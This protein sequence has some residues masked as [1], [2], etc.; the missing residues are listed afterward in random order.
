[1]T[2]MMKK[3]P[4]SD[5]GISINSRRLSS[6]P[7]KTKDNDHD[8]D[9]RDDERV[10]DFTDSITDKSGTVTSI[11]YP[12]AYPFYLLEPSI[13]FIYYFYLVASGLSNDTH[14]DSRHIVFW[15]MFLHYPV[16]MLRYPHL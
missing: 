11:R 4:M 2:Y 5:T 8:Q 7:G 1:M 10:F 14:I 3:P 16:P 9:D 12:A 6:I 13:C 15:T